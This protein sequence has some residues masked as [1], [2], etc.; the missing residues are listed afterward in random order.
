M[1]IVFL[2]VYNDDSKLNSF[3]KKKKGKFSLINVK[4]FF[5]KYPNKSLCKT[6]I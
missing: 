1:K 4:L 2:K 6:I 5:N 3:R